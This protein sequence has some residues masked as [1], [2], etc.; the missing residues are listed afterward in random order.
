MSITVNKQR[1][2]SW[3]ML[4]LIGCEDVFWAL[5]L[6][7]W[8]AVLKPSPDVFTIR[9]KHNSY[10]SPQPDPS[11]STSQT[12]PLY[13][14]DKGQ[15]AAEGLKPHSCQS[16]R[17]RSSQPFLLVFI[18]RQYYTVS[19][20]DGSGASRLCYP[21]AVVT[22]IKERTLC[23]HPGDLA[24]RQ[25]AEQCIRKSPHH[26]AARSAGECLHTAACALRLFAYLVLVLCP[27]L[28]VCSQGSE[29]AELGELEPV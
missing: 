5:S 9:P 23:N 18:P 13:T 2:G 4:T 22:T 10:L 27:R 21:V 3:D 29:T 25:A 1:P 16:G 26:L 28:D 24:I 12:L 7:D 14:A 17:V 15:P 11:S 8:A 20:A 19:A 6:S